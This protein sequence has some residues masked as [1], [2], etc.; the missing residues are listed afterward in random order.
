MYLDL[1]LFSDLNKGDMSVGIGI[2]ISK[3]L[4]G[5]VSACRQ[6]GRLFYTKKNTSILI[7]NQE[8]IQHSGGKE[9][10]IKS[11]E[12][13]QNQY[14]LNQFLLTRHT[15]SKLQKNEDQGKDGFY[16]Q[17]SGDPLDCLTPQGEEEAKK[18]GEELFKYCEKNSISHVIVI[19]GSKD[20]AKRTAQ[21]GLIIQRVLQ[22]KSLS[23]VLHEN[24][25][26]SE[27]KIG[28]TALDTLEPSI[29]KKEFL[30][31]LSE[32]AYDKPLYDG[33]ESVTD[34][35]QR[36]YKVLND[37]NCY[38]SD[39]VTRSGSAYKIATLV[40]ATRI[41]LVV[42]DNTSEFGPGKLRKG[43]SLLDSAKKIQKDGPVFY[44]IAPETLKLMKLP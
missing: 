8:F 38:F 3:F 42:L 26:L 16:R 17:K 31:M 11:A 40:I 1:S 12:G 25:D 39:E 14:F 20:M 30:K 13:T 28:E 19:T 37:A 34:F 7:Q 35:S 32:K 4:Y 44:R 33:G 6:Q 15:Q 21:T 18:L 24:P 36:M 29:I 41:G 9:L 2:R 43:N 27:I 23:T 22:N 10:S 5:P